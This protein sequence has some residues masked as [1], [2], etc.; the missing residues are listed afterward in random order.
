MQEV[1]KIDLRFKPFSAEK[2]NDQFTLCKC[3]VMALGKN[4]NLSHFTREAV[5]EALPTLPYCPVVAHLMYDDETDTYYVGGHD[6]ELNDDYKL[7]DVTVPYGVVVDNSF[8]YQDVVE[9]SGAVSTYLTCSVILWTGRYCEIMD[10]AYDDD[11]YFGQSMEII[12]CKTAKFSADPKYTDIQKFIFSALTLLG[13]SDDPDKHVEP[14]FPSA[15]VM[16]YAAD[17]DSKFIAMFSEM[18]TQLKD[19]GFMSEN[20]KEEENLDEKL[21]MLDTYGVSLD[22]LDFSLDDIALDALEEK[23]KEFKAAAAKPDD[24]QQGAEPTAFQLN[25]ID[26]L[27]EIDAELSKTTIVTDWG[28]EMSRYWLVDVQNDEVIVE[29]YTT[30]HYCGIPMTVNEDAVSLDFDAMKRKKRVYEDFV[31]G[32]LMGQYSAE[33][34]SMAQALNE[35]VKFTSDKLAQANTDLDAVTAE[36]DEYKAKCEQYEQAAAEQAKTE[37]ENGVADLFEKFDK[38]LSGS[39]VYEELKKDYSGLTLTQIEEKCFALVGQKKFSFA[40]APKAKET[41]KFGLT[42]AAQIEGAPY[43]GLFD[44]YKN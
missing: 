23:L 31:D 26:Q 43:G 25:T 2:V 39:D 38:E 37:F 28:Y 15:S 12:P 18:K 42:G 19:L 1:L 41:V 44:K 36:R 27:R 14:C 34:K 8:G 29:D 40:P 11:I 21:K 5:D 35:Q 9:V 17:T 30:G 10:A 24:D 33:T 13:K 7:I 32:T 4:R 6:R 20:N 3:Y 22:D 16:P